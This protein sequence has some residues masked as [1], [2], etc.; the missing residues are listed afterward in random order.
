VIGESDDGPPFPDPVEIPIG[1][2]IDLHRFLPGETEDVVRA[3]VE[4]AARRG[5]REVRVIHGRGRGVQRARVHRALADSPWV[6]RFSE[7]PAERGGWGA[8]LVWLRAPDASTC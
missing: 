5:F 3:Y 8:T 2:A 6:E 1:D 4:E 7:A